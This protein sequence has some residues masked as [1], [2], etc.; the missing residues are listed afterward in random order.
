MSAATR[1][2]PQQEWFPRG[3]SKEQRSERRC[4]FAMSSTSSN[5]SDPPVR[6]TLNE[7]REHR[8]GSP[9]GEARPAILDREAQPHH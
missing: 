8:S 5:P 3:C 9:L 6:V 4:A 7:R 1:E 2:S